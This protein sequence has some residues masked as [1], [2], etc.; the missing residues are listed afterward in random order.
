MIVVCVSLKTFIREMFLDTIDASEDFHM[1][2]LI[3]KILEKD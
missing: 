1:D 2:L 3:F